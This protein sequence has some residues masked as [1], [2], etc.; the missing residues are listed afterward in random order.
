LRIDVDVEKIN[1]IVVLFQK[2]IKYWCK[3]KQRV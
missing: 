3:K 2:S 1:Y